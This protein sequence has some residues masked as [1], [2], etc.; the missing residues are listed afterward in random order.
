[1][2]HL[3]ARKKSLPSLSRKRSNSA[4]SSTPS[5][6]RP[7][8]E[9]SAPYRDPRYETLLGTKGSFMVKSS[10]D[11]IS[12]SKA[13]SK[14]LL[15][16][17]QAVPVDSLF[18]DDIFEAACQKIHNKNEARVIQDIS[19]FIV[20]SAESLA[21]FG[22][23]NLDILIESV[24]EGWNNSI[25]LTG[26]RPQPDY[27]VGF[28]REA[29]NEDQLA[30]LSPFIGDF[31]SGDQSFFMAT[32]YMY[33]P[34]L[35]CEVKCGAAAL[36]VADRQNAHSMTLAV[37]AITEL[38]RAVK[39]EGEVHR[40][41]LAFSISHDHRS[42]RIYG[43]YPVLEGKDT[44][45]YRHPIR[46]FDFTELDGKEKWTAYR[47]TKNIYELWMPSHFK[48]ICSAIDQLPSDL[49][50]DNPSLPSTGLSQ[51]LRSQHLAQSDADL[52]SLPTERGSQSSN[53]KQE[54]ATPSTS[55]TNPGT[56]KKR[57]GKK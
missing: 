2:E 47:F 33:F 34:F 53:P 1:M 39:R 9:K 57:K 32:Y 19:R 41:I 22:A 51:D 18:R 31:I 5:D 11:I 21:T 42:V 43:H 28:T 45:Y 50:F 23:R 30:K 14:T 20:P 4:S 55:F 52:D 12:S 24:N 6:Q 38:F 7:R 8:E 3:L 16:A 35:T 25:P 40:Q 49:D 27:S 46:T 48:R 13:L 17:Q 37:R 44:T 56:A 29:F 54:T 15:E 10:L 26:T 36:D